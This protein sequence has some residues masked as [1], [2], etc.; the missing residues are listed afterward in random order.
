[1]LASGHLIRGGGWFLAEGVHT[2]KINYCK[3]FLARGRYHLKGPLKPGERG[4][5]NY[6]LF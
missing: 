1:V 5:E 4:R 3:A 6:I 2:I